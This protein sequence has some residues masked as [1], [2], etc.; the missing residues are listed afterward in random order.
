MNYYQKTRDKVK[1]YKDRVTSFVK[2][3]NGLLFFIIS[4]ILLLMLIFKPVHQ[5]P[6]ATLTR[7]SIYKLEE[8]KRIKDENDKLV[9]Q[10]KHQILTQEE[11][12]RERDSLAKALKLKP[13][14]IKGVDK[15]VTKV[16]TVFTNLPTTSIGDSMYQV[17]KHDAWLDVVARAGKNSGT[18]GIKQRDT[19]TR[20]EVVKDPLIG[21]TKRYT[22]IRHSSPH[23]TDTEGYSWKTVEKQTW[24]TLGPSLQYNPFS[25]KFDFGISVQ[26]PIIKLKK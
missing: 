6:N 9:S 12:K 16:D 2:S 15:L 18:I 3:H 11:T 7:D 8:V 23:I 20:I 4:I 14:F 17:E 5:V 22:Y 13:K 1:L 25:K 19:L 26:I 10:I 21:R 24:L